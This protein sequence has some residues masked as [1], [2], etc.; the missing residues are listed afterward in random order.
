MAYEDFNDLPR[1]TITDKI[2]QDK[3]FNIAKNQ[4]MTDINAELLP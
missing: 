3:T 1:R 4:N 2:L